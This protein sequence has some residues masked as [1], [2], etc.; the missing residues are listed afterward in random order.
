MKISLLL[1]SEVCPNIRE[2]GLT[3]VNDDL[4]CFLSVCVSSLIYF[5]VL[6]LI[7]PCAVKDKNNCLSLQ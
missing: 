4:T 3:S 6:E 2:V 1:L 7:F 5:P